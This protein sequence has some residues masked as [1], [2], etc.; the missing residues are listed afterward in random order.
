MTKIYAHRGASKDFPEHT[1]QAYVG[2]I[3]QGADGFECDVRLSKDNHPILWH[4]ADMVRNAKDPGFIANLTFEEI[5]N[6]YSHVLT[7][8]ELLD[9]AIENKKDLAIETKHPVPTGREVERV[10]DRELQSRRDAIAQS[11]IEVSS[12]PFHGQQ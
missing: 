10:I 11:G 4:D 7:L 6:R 12:C 2:A 9:L 3:E 1:R 5:S 8:G